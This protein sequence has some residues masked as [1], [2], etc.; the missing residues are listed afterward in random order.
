M[1]SRRRSTASRRIRSLSQAS[2]PSSMTSPISLAASRMSATRSSSGRL[3]GQPTPRGWPDRGSSGPRPRR[4][5]RHGRVAFRARATRGSGRTGSC[6]HRNQRAGRCRCRA[7]PH[8]APRSRKGPMW[9]DVARRLPTLAP[10]LAPAK[11]ISNAN[12]RQAEQAAGANPPALT[13]A[14]G[15]RSR[16]RG[17][18]CGPWFCQGCFHPSPTP[19]VRSDH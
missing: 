8:H 1:I 10:N 12:V 7:C 6:L 2:L 13:Q 4:R 9:P 17:W 16:S 5:Q 3:T 18:T 11:L 14:R 19:S 15:R